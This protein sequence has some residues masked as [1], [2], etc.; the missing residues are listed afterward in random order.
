VT[1]LFFEKLYE[2]LIFELKI[3]SKADVGAGVFEGRIFEKTSE[4]R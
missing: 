2:I 3:G 1:R 4:S